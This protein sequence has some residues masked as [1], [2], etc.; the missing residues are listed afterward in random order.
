MDFC[1]SVSLQVRARSRALWTGGLWSLMIACGGTPKAPSHAG[2]AVETP[3]QEAPA[4]GQSALSEAPSEA[5]ST[6]A[7]EPAPP[8]P[9]STPAGGVVRGI[10]GSLTGFEVEEAMNQRTPELLACVAKR[11]ARLGH[12]AGDIAFHLDVD[13]QGKVE[14]VAVM[15]S[16]IG[17]PPLEECLASV[18]ATAPLRPPNG[19]ERT[20]TQWRMSVDPL[21]RPAEPVDPG[22]L[23]ETIKRNAHATYEAC[24]IKRNRRFV[25]HGYLNQKRKLSPLSVRVPWRGPKH[26]LELPPE[27]LTCLTHELE[28]WSGWPKKRGFAKVSF[29]LRYMPPPPTKRPVKGKGKGKGK[30]PKRRA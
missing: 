21:R 13:G 1:R 25:I 17:Y 28:Q 30:A 27:D 2:D 7:E 4:W 14:R 11:P 9:P 10:T 29:E 18:V 5:S 6:P 23:D 12:V 8:P 19:A 26:I 16:D 15:Q 22:E 3:T 24:S 20:E